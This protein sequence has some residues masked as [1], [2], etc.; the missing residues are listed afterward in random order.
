LGRSPAL[1]AVEATEDGFLLKD[2][3]DAPRDV[4]VVFDDGTSRCV[5]L[6]GEVKV[7]E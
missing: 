5:S 6:D 3:A 4:R 1:I 2:L 7:E